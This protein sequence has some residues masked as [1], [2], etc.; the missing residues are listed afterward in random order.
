M[1]ATTQ[2]SA[3]GRYTS[4]LRTLAT[5]S[6]A[7]HDRVPGR[8]RDEKREMAKWQAWHKKLQPVPVTKPTEPNGFSKEDL[9]ESEGDE[10]YEGDSGEEDEWA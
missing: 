2:H 9:E 10:R 7:Y 1:L 5:S 6:W 8:T 4:Y 3:P